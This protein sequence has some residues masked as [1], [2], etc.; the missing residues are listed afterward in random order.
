MVQD[1]GPRYLATA[2]AEQ[3]QGHKR[4]DHG[5]RLGR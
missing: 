2:C 5:Y 1:Q 3:T 4:V